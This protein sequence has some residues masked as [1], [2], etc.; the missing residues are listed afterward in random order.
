MRWLEKLPTLELGLQAVAIVGLVCCVCI[1][2]DGFQDCNAKYFLCQWFSNLVP[3]VIFGGA[4]PPPPQY[5]HW[6]G[7]APLPPSSAAPV[8]GLGSGN[9]IFPFYF[10]F[11]CVKM[12]QKKDFVLA[13]CNNSTTVNMSWWCNLGNGDMENQRN[14]ANLNMQWNQRLTW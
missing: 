7:I 1:V 5:V 9:G 3:S 8:L 14:A 12:W 4:R 11:D 2:F 10:F 6:G 13:R